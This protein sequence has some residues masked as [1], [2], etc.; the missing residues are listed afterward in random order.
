MAAEFQHSHLPS[1]RSR[2]CHPYPR[3]GISGVNASRPLATLYPERCRPG[4]YRRRLSASIRT[5]GTPLRTNAKSNKFHAR[6]ISTASWINVDRFRPDC[7]VQM[8]QWSQPPPI[9]HVFEQPQGVVQPLNNASQDRILLNGPWR[10]PIGA[11]RHPPIPRTKHPPIVGF[12]R[13]IARRAPTT[14]PQRETA[15]CPGVVHL[16]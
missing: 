12:V 11:D 1:W 8:L 13:W 2:S 5:S 14:P 6:R 4:T 7:A 3:I 10:S 9:H 15:A 16:R